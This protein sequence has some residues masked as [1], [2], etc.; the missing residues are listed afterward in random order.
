MV[1]SEGTAYAALFQ[2]S[3]WM[4]LKLKP[5]KDELQEQVH[6]AADDAAALRERLRLSTQEMENMALSQELL[7]REVLTVADHH[8]DA[9][10]CLADSISVGRTFLFSELL[11]DML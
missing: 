11:E 5:Q 2:L 6:V 7:W 10:R 3:Q 9:C 4:Q 1:Q 8:S